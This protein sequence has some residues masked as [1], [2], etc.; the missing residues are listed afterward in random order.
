MKTSSEKGEVIP[1]S[2]RVIVYFELPYHQLAILP[3]FNPKSQHP[4][5]WCQFVR[6]NQEEH[7]NSNTSNINISTSITS[8]NS[9]SNSTS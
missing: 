8:T 2:P 6:T 5:V 1:H 7:N 9:F 3:I 4:I